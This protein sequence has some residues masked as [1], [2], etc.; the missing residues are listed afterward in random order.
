MVYVKPTLCKYISR[1]YAESRAFSRKKMTSCQIFLQSLKNASCKKNIVAFLAKIF[2]TF[3]TTFRPS[4][5]ILHLV[6]DEKLLMRLLA[7][8]MCSWL[9]ENNNVIRQ[10]MMTCKSHHLLMTL[11]ICL[12]L[13]VTLLTTTTTTG[14]PKSKF[15]ICFG[16]NS[17]NMC[18]WPY[19]GKAKMCLGGESLFLFFSCLFTIFNCLFTIFSKKLTVLKRI[20][21]LPT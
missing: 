21:A 12:W 19:V 16:F 13:Q 15:E 18:F 6:Y 7:S 5:L 9:H 1:F 4:R 11:A 14:W 10:V 17:E 20:L 2:S 8:A 3:W